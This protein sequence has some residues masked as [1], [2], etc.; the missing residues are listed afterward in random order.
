MRSNLVI[1]VHPHL[2][3]YLYTENRKKGCRNEKFTWSQLCF[4]TQGYTYFLFYDFLYSVNTLILYRNDTF[5][6]K[7]NL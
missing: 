5:Y 3:I 7:I 6:M 1:C 4:R 2:G